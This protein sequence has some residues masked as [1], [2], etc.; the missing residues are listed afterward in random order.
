M[1]NHQRNRFAKKI[2]STLYNT[3]SGKKIVFLGWS[4]KK[5]TNDTRE[6]A[7]IYVADQLIE[8]QAEIYVYEPKVSTDQMQADLNYL[9]TRSK[10]EN[11]KQLKTCTGPYETLIGAHAIAILTEW[12][13][14]KTYNWQ[15][16]YDNMQ[17]PAF[18]LMGGIFWSK[19]N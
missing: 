6:A 14:F 7:A 12:D 2:V 18:F 16:I 15:A 13:E 4:F 5:D 19:K 1:N 17:K 11:A 9:N 8:E 3:V 10:C